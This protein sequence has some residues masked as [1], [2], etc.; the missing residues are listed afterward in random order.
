MLSSETPPNPTSEETRLWMLKRYVLSN[1][2]SSS[3]SST[4]SS[5]SHSLQ[6]ESCLKTFATTIIL[7]P[8]NHGACI[9]IAARRQLH[10]RQAPSAETLGSLGLHDGC[11][12]LG[13]AVDILGVDSGHGDA[14]VAGHVDGVLGHELV[15]LRW[16]TKQ[17]CLRGLLHHLGSRLRFSTAIQ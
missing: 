3:S 9:D 13:K 2:C 7:L 4:L 1:H 10:A 17:R 8:C 15:N 14:A 5:S 6:H 12:A 11:H 16:N